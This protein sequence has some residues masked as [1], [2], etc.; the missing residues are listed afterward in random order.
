MIISPLNSVEERSNGFNFLAKCFYT[1]LNTTAGLTKTLVLAAGLNVGDI[2]LDAAH[3]LKTAFTTSGG[4]TALT[5]DVGWNLATGTDVP[6]GLI[7][8]RELLAAGRVLAGDGNGAAFATLR[9]GFALPES[10]AIEA[11]FTATGANLTTLT[12]GEVWIFLRS[13]N[14]SKLGGVS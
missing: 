6:N 7:V 10:G 3:Y 11:V 13:V 1:D 2:V 12:A 9:T 5:V 4:I 8:A 14:L